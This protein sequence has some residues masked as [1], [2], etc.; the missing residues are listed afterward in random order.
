MPGQWF[1]DRNSSESF[2]PLG[3]SLAASLLRDVYKHAHSHLLLFHQQGKQGSQGI[4]RLDCSLLLSFGRLCYP[5]KCMWSFSVTSQASW[6]KPL[7]MSGSKLQVQALTFKICALSALYLIGY[8]CWTNQ[9]KHSTIY[10]YPSKLGDHAPLALKRLND[11][12]RFML[13][14][15][16]DSYEMEMFSLC[17]NLLQERFIRQ[18][19]SLWPIFILLG[20]SIQ[21][22]EG[23]EGSPKHWYFQVSLALPVTTIGILG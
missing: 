2:V 7:P 16:I 6:I 17:F 8:S 21:A 23:K 10:I 14:N 5:L 22:T 18:R 9:N 13:L 1:S 11:L 20:L 19:W 4:K 3:H 15:K 12:P